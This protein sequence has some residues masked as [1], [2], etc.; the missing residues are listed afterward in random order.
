M[1]SEVF[2]AGIYGIDSY[3][4]RAEADVSSGLPMFEMVGL[5]GSEVREARDRVRIALANNG[6]EL[7]VKRI[8]VNLSPAHIK[9]SGSGFDLPVAISI[10]SAMGTVD[11]KRIKNTIFIGELSLSGKVFAV[12]GVLPMVLAAC[13]CGL[14]TAVVPID[15]AVEASMVPGIHIVAVKELADVVN[16]LN[17]GEEIQ[18][19][20][21]QKREADKEDKDDFSYINGQHMLRRACEVSA[22][23]LHNMLMVG[24]PGSGKTM[25]AKCMPSILPP[26]DEKGQMELSKIY[27]VC[28]LFANR[29]SLIDKRPFRSPHHTISQS[30]LIGGGTVVR[31]GEVSLSH[32]GILFL[33]ELTEFRRDVMEALRQPMEDKVVTVSRASGAYTYPAKF[34]L[35]AAMNPCQCGYYPDLTRCRCTDAQIDRYLGR[36]SQPMMDRIDLCVEASKL[37]YNEIS[38]SNEN[39][40][41]AEIRKR[42]L[43]ATE[44]QKERY[45]HTD[46]ESN[47][48]IPSG[49]IEEFCYLG[50]KE[51]K[52]MQDYYSKMNLTAR[53]YHKIL[54]VARTIADL[55]NSP[56][57]EIRHLQEA[58]CYRTL[59]KQDWE[60]R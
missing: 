52:M 55:E 53:T 5:L 6:Y 42:V 23:G 10:L 17:T 29:S 3:I 1:Y 19:E 51:K 54:R 13:E 28:G 25:V 12:N 26:L 58:V 59:D 8:T 4:V 45:K 50:E 39:E 31:P 34:I 24:P 49:R 37:S 20:N 11:K 15:N 38:Y 47:S 57:I 21:E 46:I 36:I 9:K 35:V 40:S 14:K 41:S 7:P 30:G 60:R 2:C 56:G 48:S 32:G 27:S 43:A 44:I 33:D 18:W 16:Y 22:A